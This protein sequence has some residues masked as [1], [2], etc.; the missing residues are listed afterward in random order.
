LQSDPEVE[1]RRGGPASTPATLPR[2]V[3]AVLIDGVIVGAVVAP[4]FTIGEGRPP[5]RIV[6]AGPSVQSTSPINPRTFGIEDAIKHTV[7]GTQFGVEIS[8]LDGHSV[9]GTATGSVQCQ[10]ANCH[11]V[12]PLNLP[13]GALLSAIEVDGCDTSATDTLALQLRSRPANEGGATTLLASATTSGAPGCVFVASA[14]GTPVTIDNANNVYFYHVTFGG[15]TT[16]VTR[17]Q[18]VR[19]IYNLQVSPAP[20]VASFGDV[21]LGHPF[22]R[23]VEA[24]KASGITGGCQS[25]PPLFCP[26]A[27]LT[28]G[29]MATFLSLA[30]GLHF[31]P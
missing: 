4:A 22:F 25:A 28:R 19:A 20:A 23:F 31:A 29:Q 6:P 13:A 7:G 3:G 21:P 15:N 5:T 9:S 18:A 24:L 17:L 10:Q 2:R 1:A 8:S 11:L 26:D 12:A 14:L 16:G 27:P 30:L